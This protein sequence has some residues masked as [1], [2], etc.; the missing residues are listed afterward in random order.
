MLGL[1]SV[2]LL[3][4]FA[5]RLSVPTRRDDAPRP[6]E[7]SAMA[8]ASAPSFT[9]PLPGATT[10]RAT[11]LVPAPASAWNEDRW[12]ELHA[13]PASP[14][15][16]AELAILLERCAAADPARALALAQAEGNLK[17]RDQLVHAALRGWAGVAPAA[18]ADWALN[19]PNSEAR[20]NA[21]TAVL[22]GSVSASPD[23]AIQLG[24]S[25][26]ER[27]PDDAPALGSRLIDTFCE[28][29][30]FETA[31]R[32][33]AQGAPDTR[34]GW[35]ANAYF[36]W[37]EFQPEQAAAAASALKDP[38]ARNQALQGIVGGW[39]GTDPAAAVKFAAQVPAD[40]GQASLLGRALAS[41]VKQDPKAASAWIDT[42]ESRP[43]LDQ[44]VAAVATVQAM[45]ADVALSWAESI[46]NPA[47]RSETLA[48]VVR[49]W[50]TADPSAARAY[51][52]TNT[53]ILPADR[54]PLEQ[55]FAGMEIR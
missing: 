31:A 54:Q 30:Q 5:G 19:L 17:L 22:R 6:R 34:P 39:G 26:V 1:A 7:G 48:T 50:M 46:H 51:F 12:S 40:S 52:Q 23:N 2:G 32:I 11:D 49:N 16:N 38:S 43:E 45:K 18:A 3:C 13:A 35:V 36:H 14:G 24:R 44:G 25:L 21:L 20:D 10:A 15:R 33:A 37:A 53:D 28:S 42:R 8:I 29:G 4:F 55:V 41:W 27:Y 9:A 47:L